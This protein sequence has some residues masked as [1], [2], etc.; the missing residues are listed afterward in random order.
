MSSSLI[1]QTSEE[2]TV[3]TFSSEKISVQRIGAVGGDFLSPT[4]TA[5]LLKPGNEVSGEAIFTTPGTFTF[6]VPA[7]VRK[8]SALAV[9]GGGG[10]GSS[11]SQGPGTGAAL[12]WADDIPV[13]AGQTISITVAGTASAGQNGAASIVGSFFSA[14][15]G[16]HAPNGDN[17]GGAPQSGTVSASGGTGGMAY[18]TSWEGGGGG[19]GGY[20]GKGGNGYY[21]PS[22]TLPYN[23][24]GG[25][26]A[27]GTGYASSTYA[28]A[29]GGG[30]GIFG[31][32]ASGTW[33]SLPNQSSAPSNSG[34]SFYSDLRYSG[35]AGSGGEHGAPSSNGTTTSNFGRTQYSGEGGRYGG[36]GGGSGTNLSG[37]SSFGAGAQGAV[38]IVWST[39]RTYSIA[40]A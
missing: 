6:V 25:G 1:N 35:P 4:E 5:E 22:G 38:R 29:G 13:T 39:K 34:N 37:S 9:G 10:G 2:V 11:W 12:A 33:G 7:G 28:F 27:G 23:G 15:G 17:V 16:R 14:Q 21:G 20:T 8:I 36:G 31:Q 3:P 32:G 24:S 30:V 18:S 40:V 19:A 26:G